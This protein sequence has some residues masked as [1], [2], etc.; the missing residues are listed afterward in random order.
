MLTGGITYG[1]KAFKINRRLGSIYSDLI[2]DEIYGPLNDKI[3]NLRFKVKSIEDF[4][5]DEKRR[6]HL[7]LC[8]DY[9]LEEKRWKTENEVVIFLGVRLPS[10]VSLGTKKCIASNICKNAR[11]IDIGTG[12]Y[13]FWNKGKQ[14]GSIIPVGLPPPPLYYGKTS[15]A[16]FFSTNLEN[17]LWCI[18]N[19]FKIDLDSIVLFLQ[20]GRF[21]AGK[22]I[23]TDIYSLLPG[24]ILTCN[25]E[26]LRVQNFFEPRSLFIL[27]DSKRKTTEYASL[28]VETM[29]KVCQKKRVW[30]SLSGGLDSMILYGATLNLCRPP[31]YITVTYHDGLD[32]IDEYPIVKKISLH[33]NAVCKNLIVDYRTFFEELPKRMQRISVPQSVFCTHELVAKSVNDANA[34]VA[35]GYGASV[36]FSK[37][38][39]YTWPTLKQFFQGEDRTLS[40]VYMKKHKFWQMFTA[41]YL[42]SLRLFK[43]QEVHRLIPSVSVDYASEVFE[44]YRQHLSQELTYFNCNV[45]DALAYLHAFDYDENIFLRDIA[46]VSSRK[47]IDIICPYTDFNMLKNRISYKNLEQKTNNIREQVARTL[48][49][50]I[51]RIVSQDFTP[52]VGHWINKYV[53]PL[54]LL[55]KDEGGKLR[56]MSP[57][58]IAEMCLANMVLTEALKKP[59]GYCYLW[60]LVTLKILFAKVFED[61]EL[62]NKFVSSCNKVWGNQ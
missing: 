61:E 1:N 27:P 59:N 51:E 23:L 60:A 43:A 29:N 34:T 46:E 30:I 22:S 33:H 45:Y 21:P 35:F 38:V 32:I 36:F 13:I 12:F 37:S 26:G 58:G 50:C 28:L 57:S 55:L 20:L 52:P 4:R 18:G 31:R 16:I 47:G 11:T 48:G 15:D 53:L 6:I 54:S 24:Q 56:F 5:G 62:W 3:N 39:A 2:D 10:N 9:K 40:P 19:H 8:V 25:S 17:L 42:E 14:T 49:I 7:I 41:Q 44:D